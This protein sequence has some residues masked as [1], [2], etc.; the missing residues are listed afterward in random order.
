MV[1]LL[2]Q[3]DSAL[4]MSSEEETTRQCVSEGCLL[5]R[6]SGVVAQV[7]VRSTKATHRERG[8]PGI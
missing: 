5:R 8:A 6:Q 7:I 3:H 2:Y 1:R 4:Q